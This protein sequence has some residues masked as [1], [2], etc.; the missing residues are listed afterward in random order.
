MWDNGRMIDLGKLIAPD[1]FYSMAIG[2]N[3]RGEVVGY[4]VAITGVGAVMW[5]P[6]PAAL[7]R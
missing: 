2:V 7:Y 3:N 4:S 6:F 1:A 5:T